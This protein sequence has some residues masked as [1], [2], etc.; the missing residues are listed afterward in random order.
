MVEVHDERDV[1]ALNRLLKINPRQRYLIRL[2]PINHLGHPGVYANTAT[3]LCYLYK[4]KVRQEVQRRLRKALQATKKGLSRQESVVGFAF[5]EE[6][7]G[8]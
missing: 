5:L 7:P 2:W 6:L 8:W 4:P 3:F 1:E